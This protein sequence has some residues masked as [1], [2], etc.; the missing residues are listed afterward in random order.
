MRFLTPLALAF[1]TLAPFARAESEGASADSPQA[2]VVATP[3]Q[4]LQTASRPVALVCGL[5]ALAAA[6]YQAVASSKPRPR[7]VPVK[8]D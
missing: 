8:A 1:L 7:A 5:L 2:A 6:A 4:S 3:T